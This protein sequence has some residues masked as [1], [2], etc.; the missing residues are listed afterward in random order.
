MPTLLSHF[1]IKYF[2]SISFY[3]FYYCTLSFYSKYVDCLISSMPNTI[4]D[5]QDCSFY[6]YCHKGPYLTKTLCKRDILSNTEKH[7]LNPYSIDGGTS[8]CWFFFYYFS[9]YVSVLCCSSWI[10]SFY[11]SLFQRTGYLFLILLGDLFY[12][13][14]GF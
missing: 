10:A 7:L 6:H 12:S 11:P 3:W 8:C 4:N 9:P 2:T 5:S 14:P 1:K 13:C